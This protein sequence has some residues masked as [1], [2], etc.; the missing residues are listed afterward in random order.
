MKPMVEQTSYFTGLVY[1]AFKRHM[2]VFQDEAFSTEVTAVGLT[3]IYI[4]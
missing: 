4:N 3:L 2:L 1:L